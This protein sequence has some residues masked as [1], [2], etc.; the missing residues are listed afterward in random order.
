MAELKLEQKPRKVQISICSSAGLSHS[1]AVSFFRMMMFSANR[2]PH[3]YT[4]AYTP[5]M[6]IHSARKKCCEQAIETGADYI[7]FL[8]DDMV[9]PENMIQRLVAIADHGK[10][11]M[12]S[13][14]Y[15]NRAKEK[16]IPL[17]YMRQPNEM[18][19]AYMIKREHVGKIIACD[20]TG[21]GAL[22]IRTEMLHKIEKPWFEIPDSMTEDIY[23]FNKCHDLGIPVYID[24][25]LSCGHEGTYGWCFPTKC[26]AEKQVKGTILRSDELL[27]EQDYK[28]KGNG[29][30]KETIEDAGNAAVGAGSA[31]SGPITICER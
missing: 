27:H 1:A 23:F 20:A 3:A 22:L 5:R 19:S 18:Y 31:G 11:D 2:T 28:P 8:D 21:F 25:G 6:F 4:L 26:E 10:Y 9:W 30:G 17:S 12:V 7:M 24:T 13:G 16:P 29:N 15:T 14:W